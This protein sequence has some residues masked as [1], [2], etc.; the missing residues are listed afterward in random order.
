MIIPCVRVTDRRLFLKTALLEVKTKTHNHTFVA[1]HSIRPYGKAHTDYMSRMK[2]DSDQ[3]AEAE[4]SGILRCFMPG[5]NTT[6]TEDASLRF[7]NGPFCADFLDPPG[8]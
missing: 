7:P 4:A 3:T 5:S 8:Q 2:K 6:T 1:L